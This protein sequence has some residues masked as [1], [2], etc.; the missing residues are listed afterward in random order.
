[1]RVFIAAFGSETNSFVPFPTTEADF[2]RLCLVRPDAPLGVAIANDGQSEFFRRAQARGHE[3]VRGTL[4]YA[5]PSGPL[6]RGCYEKLRDEILGQLRAAA[7]VDAVLLN[8]HGAML[9]DGYDD[10][11]GDLLARAR[12]IVGP[13]CTIGGLL[14]PHG[15]LTDEMLRAATLLVAYKEYP[16]VDFAACARKL[17]DLVERAAKGAI[18]PIMAMADCR[19]LGSFPT[20]QGPMRGFVDAMRAMESDPRVLDLSLIH[21]FPWGDCPATGTRTLAVTD[22]DPGLAG[23]LAELLRVRFLSIREG[24]AQKFLSLNEALARNVAG[25]GPIIWADSSD[26]PGGG[27]PGDSTYL[28]QALLENAIAPAAIAMIWD[29]MTIEQCFASGERACLPVRLGGKASRFSGAPL[30]LDVEVLRLRDDAVQHFGEGTD[31]RALALGRTAA[32]RVHDV[33]IVVTER[34]AQTFSPECLTAFGLDPMAYRVIVVK[35]TNHFRAAFGPL[36]RD[37]LDVGSPGALGTDL[38]RLPYRKLRRPI[39]PLERG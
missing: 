13:R 12:A 27:A 18:D 1:M 20:V 30:D 33:D 14:D 39:W 7:P 23:E 24:A 21:S 22:G 15:H 16:H 38:A 9:A 31:V 17:F 10:C 3:I 37:I 2:A 34:R 25:H 36:A 11:E 5:Q 26:N 6:T 8:L 28:L 19:T 29:P 32:L 35:S 4:A